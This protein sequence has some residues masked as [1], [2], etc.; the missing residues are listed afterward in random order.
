MSFIWICK[1]CGEVT[2]DKIYLSL[3]DASRK[4]TRC[5]GKKGHCECF[6][7]DYRRMQGKDDY[8]RN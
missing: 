3:D 2:S 4:L 6:L 1:K 5:P 8:G 7:A